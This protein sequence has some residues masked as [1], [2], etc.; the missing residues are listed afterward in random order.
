MVHSLKMPSLGCQYH[1]QDTDFGTKDSVIGIYTSILKYKDVDS[2]L[3]FQFLL[4]CI[5]LNL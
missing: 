1:T 5:L 4:D 2:T 3:G